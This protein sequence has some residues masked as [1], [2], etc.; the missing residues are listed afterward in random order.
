MKTFAAI[1]LASTAVAQSCSESRD[2]TFNIQITNVTSSSEKRDLSARQLSGRLTVSLK[3][4]VLKDQAGR[5]GNI[6]ANHQFQFDSPLQDGSIY[7]DGFGICPN[8][9]LTHQGSAIWYQC[10]SG[11]FYNLYDQ[12]QGAQCNQVY[13]NAVGGSSAPVTQVRSI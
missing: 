11:T 6:V 12:S 13:F 1:A 10:L 8:G 4:G 9:T 7:Q 5:T 2:G 3:D